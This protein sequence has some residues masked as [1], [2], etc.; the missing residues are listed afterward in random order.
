M[1]VGID[2]ALDINRSVYLQAISDTMALMEEYKQLCI[3]VV[4]E[5]LSDSFEIR[6]VSNSSRGYYMVI[7][8][9]NKAKLSS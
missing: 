4:Y 5:W 2:G 7:A 6:G 9:K 8:N 1:R 3:V